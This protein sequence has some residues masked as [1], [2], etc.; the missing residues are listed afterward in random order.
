[1][2]AMYSIWYKGEGQ[3][4]INTY[5]RDNLQTWGGVVWGTASVRRCDIY[6]KIWKWRLNKSYYKKNNA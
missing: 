2:T 1:M 3:G 6:G 4:D 5:N